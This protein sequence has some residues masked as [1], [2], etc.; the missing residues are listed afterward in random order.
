MS[1]RSIHLRVVFTT[2]RI[3]WF[4]I[5]IHL[6][7]AVSAT[8]NEASASEE[9]SRSVRRESWSA[10]VKASAVNSHDYKRQI[11]RYHRAHRDHT[12]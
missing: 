2:R 9:G 4:W 12:L 5:R 8:A 1:E 3:I 7:S 6:I 10:A 11:V